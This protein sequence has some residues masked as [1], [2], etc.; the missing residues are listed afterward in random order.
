MNIEKA[1]AILSGAYNTHIFNTTKTGDA[2]RPNTIKK[3][4]LSSV[5]KQCLLYKYME[6]SACDKLRLH[7]DN[8]ILETIDL[9]LAGAL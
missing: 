2:M 7:G 1:K 4:N 5:D 9:V 6:Y 3:F 8:E